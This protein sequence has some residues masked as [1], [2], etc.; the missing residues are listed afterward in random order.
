MNIIKEQNPDSLAFQ[1]SFYRDAMARYSQYFI[2]EFKNELKIYYEPATIEQIF[3]LI[4]DFNKPQFMYNEINDFYQKNKGQYDKISDLKAVIT[5]LYKIGLLGN[6][7]DG[8][9]SFGYRFDGKNKPNFLSKFI[10]HYGAK[11]SLIV[12]KNKKGAKR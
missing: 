11:K 9:V 12:K 4:S 1:P 6:I 8:A 5:D 2:G 10:V 3:D 7:T